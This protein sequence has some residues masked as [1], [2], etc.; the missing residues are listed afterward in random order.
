MGA[1]PG[2]LAKIFTRKSEVLNALTIL[3]ALLI[4]SQF[5]YDLGR[6][7]TII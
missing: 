4:S 7:L 5:I 3:L 1:V 2:I 6:I